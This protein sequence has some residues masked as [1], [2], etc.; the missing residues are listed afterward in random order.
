MI[1]DSHG[2]LGNILYPGGG[3]LIFKK[4]VKKRFVFDIATL[5]EWQ[6]HAGMPPILYKVLLDPIARS[7]RARNG[8]ATK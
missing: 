5:S 8:T 3:E 4:G 2:H 7:E 6:L 1:I